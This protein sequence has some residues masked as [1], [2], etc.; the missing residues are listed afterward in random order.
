[1]TKTSFFAPLAALSLLAA[2]AAP[3][4][5]KAQDDQAAANAGGK[6]ERKICRTI[7]RTESRMN[8][9]RLCLTKAEWRKLENEQ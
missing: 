7:P 8:A 2:G 4:F 3:A 1:M 6:E 9:K 5:A